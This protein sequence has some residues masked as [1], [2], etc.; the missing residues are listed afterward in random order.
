MPYVFGALVGLLSILV[1]YRAFR[2]MLNARRRFDAG[3][4]S[5]Y[6]L[7]QKRGESDDRTF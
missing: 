3:E 1:A 6:W 4:V 7:Q 5:E 2:P